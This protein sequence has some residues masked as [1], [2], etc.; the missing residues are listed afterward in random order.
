MN[1]KSLRIFVL[2]TAAAAIAAAQKTAKSTA[3]GDALKAVTMA[4]ASNKPDEVIS[5]A[6]DFVAKYPDSDFKSSVLAEA[7]KAYDMQ[8]KFDKAVSEGDL[9]IE[10][11]PKNFQAMILVAG[12]LAQHTPANDLTRADKLAKADKYAKEALDAISTAPKPQEKMT[13]A[14]WT[15]AKAIAT[16][17]VHYDMGL[18]AM[19]RR[20]P[21]Q[22]AA[23]YKMAVDGAGGTPD[24]IWL[25]RLGDAYLNSGKP[26][27]AIEAFDRVLATKD[28]LPNVKQVAESEKASAQKAKKK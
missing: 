5:K 27:E 28:V 25:V 3:E 12:E 21:G 9:A 22:A 4:S 20:Q 18:I 14:D 19:A 24:P 11:D 2:L 10:A 1:K 26:D 6:N 13:D 8:S 17:G 16:A 7:A 15:E 23:E